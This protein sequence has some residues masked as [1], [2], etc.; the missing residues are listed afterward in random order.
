MFF[1]TGML[2]LAGD[3]PRTNEYVTVKFALQ[4]NKLKPGT[5]GELVISFKPRDGIHIN[6]DPPI[7]IKFDTSDAITSI[8]KPILPAPTK[9]KY[10]DTARPIKQRFTVSKKIKPGIMTL[11]GTLSYFYCSGTDGWCSRFKQPFE[12]SVTITK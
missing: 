10:F 4:Q 1:S 8:E 9:E 11:K 6:L 3:K 2:L 5:M 7:S 12:I